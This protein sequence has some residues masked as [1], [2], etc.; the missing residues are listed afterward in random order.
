M[1]WDARSQGSEGQAPFTPALLLWEGAAVG[2]GLHSRGRGSD[3]GL[4][5]E[6]EAQPSAPCWE[7]MALAESLGE[8]G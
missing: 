7:H 2:L 4:A 5:G 8:T 6:A 1:S 3:L